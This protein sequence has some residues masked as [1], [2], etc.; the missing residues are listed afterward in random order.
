IAY[1]SNPTGADAASGTPETCGGKSTGTGCT[2]RY[3]TLTGSDEKKVMSYREAYCLVNG[4]GD[5]QN[6]C[7]NTHFSSAYEQLS[8]CKLTTPNH[9]DSC[10]VTPIKP[11]FRY[12][13]N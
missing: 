5:Y 6:Y 7:S 9:Y 4:S 3:Y 13:F 10:K 11:A 12:S 1:I 2:G 8:R